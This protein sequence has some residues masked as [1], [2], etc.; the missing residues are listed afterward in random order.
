MLMKKLTALLACV[1]ILASFATT[2]VSAAMA[3]TD[4]A[5]PSWQS[6]GTPWGGNLPEYS[7][8]PGGVTNWGGLTAKAAKGPDGNCLRITY[9]GGGNWLFLSYLGYPVNEKRIVSS[10]LRLFLG[11]DMDF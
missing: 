8:A 7:V 4:P 1:C 5:Y 6:S 9:N 2:S 3:T 10:I 11:S